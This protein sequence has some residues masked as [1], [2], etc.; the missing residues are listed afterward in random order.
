MTASRPAHNS[1]HHSPDDSSDNSPHHF[2][3]DASE[4][5]GGLLLYAQG[6]WEVMARPDQKPP[7][8][9][10]HIWLLLG[11]RGSG[12]TRTGAEWVRDQVWQQ[13]KRH[14]ALIAPSLGEAREVMLS[15]RSGL[16]NVG[17][18]A[19]RPSYSPA[20]RRLE[21]SNGAVGYVYSAA[22]PDSL[23]G[24]Q[25]DCAWADEF[26]AW[27]YAQDT[28]AN[29]R[30]A[31]RLGENPQ[32]VLT[33]TPKPGPDLRALMAMPGLVTSRSRT[34]WNR[35]HLSSGFLDMMEDTYGGTALAR[36]EMDG[37]IVEDVS[38]GLWTRDMF[39]RCRTGK[40]P[41]FDK[42]ILAVDPPA[43][44]DARGD[45]CGIIVAGWTAGQAQETASRSG[46]VYIL[47]DGTV[48]GL[49]TGTWA[50]TVM[51][52]YRA[53][54]AD[55]IVIEK[56]M[57]GDM[58]EDILRARAPH[59]Q[60]RPVTASRGKRS[61]A[62][63]AAHAYEQGRVFHMRSAKL[64]PL[65]DELLALG[66]P[67]PRSGSSSSPDRADALVWAVTDLLIKLQAVPRVRVV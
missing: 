48:R 17:F 58:V 22:D 64:G 2:S 42:I 39:E 47:R 29:L 40:H 19:Q 21:W 60:I 10:W 54:D 33:T 8:V 66:Q 65:E 28:L 32:L 38:G 41:P 15:G 27:P 25:F 20:R 1:A 67:G 30:L 59:A 49:S 61:R 18:S 35:A 23:R 37:E 53:W 5:P 12:K 43:C 50:D 24:P 57:G 31:L 6:L 14:V 9:P 11:G 4:L 7:K 51:R 46:Q 44:R 16:M 52:L 63:P 55:Y 34:A 26:C 56:N 3:G 36:Q 13:G 62:E 45:A